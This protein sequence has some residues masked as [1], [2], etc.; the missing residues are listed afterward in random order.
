MKFESELVWQS[1]E[2]EHPERA[3]A[4]KAK[5]NIFLLKNNINNPTWNYYN[6]FNFV[7]LNNR[8]NL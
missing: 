6:L 1:G 5:Q 8:L 2:K 3:K 4:I 7:V